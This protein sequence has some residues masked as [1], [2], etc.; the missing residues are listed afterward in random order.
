MAKPDAHWFVII[1]VSALIS[2]AMSAFSGYA[3]N[4]RDIIQRVTATEAHATDDRKT[5][6]EIKAAL[7]DTNDKVTKILVIVGNR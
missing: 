1:I 6:E 3:S 2:L 7:K 4:D 5:L